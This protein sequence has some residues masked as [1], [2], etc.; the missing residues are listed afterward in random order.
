MDKAGGLKSILYMLERMNA[1]QIREALEA[2]WRIWTH[3]AEAKQ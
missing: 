2:V 3:G 1:E